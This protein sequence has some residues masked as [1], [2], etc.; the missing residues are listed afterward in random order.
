MTDI[1][2]QAWQ[3]RKVPGA[4]VAVEAIFTISTL[5][6]TAPLRPALKIKA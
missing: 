6:P 4:D 1:V 2:S 3:V 5:V